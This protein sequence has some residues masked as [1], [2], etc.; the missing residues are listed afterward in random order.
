MT[1]YLIPE[2]YKPWKWHL[3]WWHQTA[4]DVADAIAEIERLRPF[5]A[6]YL[7]AVRL[8]DERRKDGMGRI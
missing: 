2:W 1:K 8:E 4:V 5:E 6:F 3:P 7:E